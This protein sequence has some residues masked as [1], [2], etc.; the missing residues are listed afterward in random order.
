MNSSVYQKGRAHKAASCKGTA[1]S[2]G[3]KETR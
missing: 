3:K 1:T 2:L